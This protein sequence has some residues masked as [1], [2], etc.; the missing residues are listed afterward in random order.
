[1]RAAF[2]N[3]ASGVTV[4]SARDDDGRVYAMTVAA[5]TPVSVDPP[6][7]IVC[8]HNDSPL[9]SVLEEGVRC[10]VSI[11]TEGQKRAA[12]TFADRFAVPADL[13]TDENVPVVV[14]AGATLV[15]TVERV[16]DGGDH[17]LVVIAVETAHVGSGDLPPLVYWTRGYRRLAPEV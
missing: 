6:L 14:D 9:A 4:V 12:T 3:W 17:R 16:D 1:V 5:F 11:L 15:G 2:A 8:V 13:L 7:V 10:A